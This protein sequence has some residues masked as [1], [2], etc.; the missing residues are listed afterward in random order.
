MLVPSATIEGYVSAHRDIMFVIDEA[1]A[2][3]AFDSAV[4]LT[5]KYNNIMV[6]RTFSKSRSMAGARLGYAIADTEI[7]SDM[8]T[9]KFSTNPYSVNTMTEKC[10]VK[11]LDHGDLIRE[12]C[13]II[14]QNRDRLKAELIKRDFDVTDSRANFVFAKHKCLSGAYIYQELRKKGIL[15]RH[16]DESRIR[17]YNRITIGHWDDMEKLLAAL[18]EITEEAGK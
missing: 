10:A 14:S 6:V 13:V 17:D 7:I 15:V 16:F 1:Y 9:V 5:A 12:R 2:D 18:D 3:F 11:Y 8:N 4:A